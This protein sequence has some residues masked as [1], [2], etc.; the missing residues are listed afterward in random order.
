MKSVHKLISSEL[1]G[2]IDDMVK[3]I[4]EFFGL[5]ISAVQA[6]RIVSW[7]SRSYNITLT[8][9]KL[10]EILGGKIK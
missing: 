7:K 8:E 9:K 1:S 5:D 10:I 6:S 4:K 3:K 2:Q